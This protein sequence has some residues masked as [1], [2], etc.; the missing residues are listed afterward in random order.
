MLSLCSADYMSFG[1][2]GVAAI[3]ALKANK[4]A[5]EIVA[6]RICGLIAPRDFC[7][8]LDARWTKLWLYAASYFVSLDARYECPHCS[9]QVLATKEQP[10][11][12]EDHLD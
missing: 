3:E 7:S 4:E 10:V 9:R 8:R 1:P 11:S 2:Y 5:K 6:C 12:D